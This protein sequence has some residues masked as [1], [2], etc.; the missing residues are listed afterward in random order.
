MVDSPPPPTVRPHITRLDSLTGMRF[1]AA[2]CVFMFH[3]LCTMLFADRSWQM[4]P[5]PGPHAMVFWQGNWTSVSFFFVLSGFV[6]AWSRRPGDTAARFWRRRVFKI[7]PNHLLTLIAAAVLFGGLLGLPLDGTTGVLNAFLV[8]S[9]WPQ[10]EV[11]A[12]YN[13]VSW[14][15]SCEALFYLLFPLLMRYIDRIRPERLWAAAGVVLAAVFAVPLVATLLPDGP[16]QPLS[17]SGPVAFWFTSKFPPVRL[18]EFVFGLLLARIVATGRRVPLGLGGATALTVFAYVVAPLFPL[19]YPQVAVTLLPLGLIIAAAAAGEAAGVRAWTGG[20]VMVWLGETSFAFY[21]CHLLILVFTGSVLLGGRGA[22]TPVALGVLAL[23]FLAS[24]G[25]A[26]LLFHLVE[27]PIM[28][29]FATSRRR[30]LPP[31]AP[32]PPGP[33]TTPAEPALN[34]PDPGR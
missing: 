14:S 17:Q 9:F 1:L 11:W 16:W 13:S 27:R 30:P 20:R 23:V 34:A 3:G 22:S 5:A 24:L 8:Q 19:T 33:G 7:W 31:L 21:M 25:V 6:L 26:A 12:S 4:T 15:L 28:R 10:Q 32:I 18:L 2:V 29:R